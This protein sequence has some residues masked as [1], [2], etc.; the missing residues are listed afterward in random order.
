MDRH[1]SR[2]KLSAA[3]TSS[4]STTIRKA[5]AAV[6]LALGGVENPIIVGSDTAFAAAS[7]AGSRRS[8]AKSEGTR[9]DDIQTLLSAEAVA[10][11]FLITSIEIAQQQLAI[12]NSATKV[13]AA[14]LNGVE[15]HLRMLRV[16][17][18][19]YAQSLR[20]VAAYQRSRGSE[21]HAIEIENT[22]REVGERT[23]RIASDLESAIRRHRALK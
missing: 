7:D 22:A 8:R 11:S 13:D 14:Y 4:V 10:R 6:M 1:V 15:E 16:G 21:E 18:V 3:D 12:L 23:D 19:G 2:D 17:L 5:V 20:D 9:A